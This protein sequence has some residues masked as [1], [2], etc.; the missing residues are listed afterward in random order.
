MERWFFLRFSERLTEAYP[1][2][3]SGGDGGEVEDFSASG[4]FAKRYGWFNTLYALCD[5][6]VTKFNEVTKTEL[7]IALL[8]T[9]YKQGKQKIESRR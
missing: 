1:D 7:S 3:F 5:G 9:E 6:D 2:I 4:Q 8:F